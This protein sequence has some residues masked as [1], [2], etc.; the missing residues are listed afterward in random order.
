MYWNRNFAPRVLK[1]SFHTLLSVSQKN[2]NFPTRFTLITVS[3]NV[4]YNN[5]T[6]SNSQSWIIETGVIFIFTILFF[7]QWKNHNFTKEKWEKTL[8]KPLV[9]TLYIVHMQKYVIH[10][11]MSTNAVLSFNFIDYTRLVFRIN[12]VHISR[13]FHHIKPN[14]DCRF[15]IH[16]GIFS[17]TKLLNKTISS[18]SEN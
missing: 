15:S 12:L 1:T 5:V 7:N 2:N 17:Y 10:F 8:K 18:I 11:F 4:K 14:V 6:L 16:P 3:S 9:D 13:A